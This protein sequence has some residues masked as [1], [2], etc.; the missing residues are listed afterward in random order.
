MSDVVVA[1]LIRCGQIELLLSSSFIA[2]SV[3]SLACPAV[4]FYITLMKLLFWRIFLPSTQHEMQE[5]QFK[6]RASAI[7]SFY[8]QACLP[9]L[10]ASIICSLISLHAYISAS[11][12]FLVWDPIAVGVHRTMITIDTITCPA[13]DYVGPR[14]NRTKRLYI[15]L[16]IIHK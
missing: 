12:Y 15:N 9:T 2:E 7:F 4:D 11:N 6:L 1:L 3:E 5:C 10:R 8:S 14:T 16:F 13:F